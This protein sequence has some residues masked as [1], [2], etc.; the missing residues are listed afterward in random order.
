MNPKND[1]YKYDLMDHAKNPRNY[2]LM[3]GA[4]F[5]VKQQNLSCGDSVTMCGQIGQGSLIK[6]SFEGSGCVLSVAMASK[7]TEHLIGKT[8]DEILLLDD[9]IVELLLGMELGINRLQCGLLSV[10]AIK[11]GIHEY[12]Q[13][14]SC[15]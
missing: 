12:L 4:S 7:L 14:Q 15:Q 13:R 1:L 11:Q 9:Q 10:A 6:L 5:C 8:L 2:G 3:S